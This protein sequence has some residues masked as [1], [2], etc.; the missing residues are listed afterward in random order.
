M[1]TNRGAA[2]SIKAPGGSAT[3]A[4][5]G[6]GRDADPNDPGDYDA[7]YDSSWH[8]THVAGTIAAKTDN[9]AGTVVI[10]EAMALR[11]PVITTYVA[12]IPELVIPGET[13]WLVPAASIEPLVQAMEACL[14]AP[15]ETLERMGETA[16]RRVAARHDIDTEAAKLVSL[17]TQTRVGREI[18]DWQL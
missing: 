7:F 10:M 14:T 6:D 18:E 2:G 16:Y 15:P 12:G 11:R 9:G 1:K 3:G 8:G 17:F 13:G 5:D 4:A